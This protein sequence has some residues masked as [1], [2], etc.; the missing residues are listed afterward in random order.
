MRQV[1]RP[2]AGAGR[3]L[4]P[5]EDSETGAMEGSGQ[6]AESRLRTHLEATGPSAARGEWA[7]R[8]KVES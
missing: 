5:R 6:R 3:A 8:R 2:G 4:C 7:K 1:E